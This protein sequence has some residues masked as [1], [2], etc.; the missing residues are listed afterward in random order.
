MLMYVS[1]KAIRS[2]LV[3]CPLIY[4]KVPRRP[5]CVDVNGD[6]MGKNFKWIKEEGSWEAESWCYPFALLCSAPLRKL[7]VCC[8]PVLYFFLLLPTIISEFYSLLPLGNKTE[9]NRPNPVK[10]CIGC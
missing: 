7:L 3:L 2:Y 5:F 10:K 1:G 8:T 9:R 6:R 4:F